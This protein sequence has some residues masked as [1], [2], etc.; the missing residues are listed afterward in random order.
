M[1]SDLV[2]EKNRKDH[3]LKTHLCER[4]T[5]ETRR[6]KTR[7]GIWESPKLYAVPVESILHP[8]FAVEETPGM[9][10][11]TDKPLF[12][13]VVKDHQTQWSKMFPLPDE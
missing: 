3:L 11:A 6:H 8:I 13:W 12:C 1:S 7:G 2:D 9:H 5:L 4:W 10:E